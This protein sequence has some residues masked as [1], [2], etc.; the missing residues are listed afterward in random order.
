[1][2]MYRQLLPFGHAFGQRYELPIP[3]LLFVLGGAG[4]VLLSF[5]IVLQR[6]VKAVPTQEYSDT[7][8][9]PQF[10][11]PWAGISLIGLLMLVITGLY[12]SQEVAENIV[13]TLFWLVVWIAVPL[14]C[15]VVG[16]F[17]RQL[18]PFLQTARIFDSPNLRRRLIAKIEPMAWPVWLSWW[19]AVAL[20]FVLAAGELIFNQT[21]TL[22]AVTA[23]GAI[24]YAI[25]SAVMGL[26]YGDQWAMKGEVF[27]VLF[28]TWGRL[29]WFRFGDTGTSGLAGGLAHEPFE[30]AI[31][32]IIFVVLLLVNVGLDGLLSTPFWA[33]FIY[34]L[35]AAISFGTTG[36]R[37]FV[38]A[39][40]GVLAITFVG[41]LYLFARAVAYAGAYR[42]K[43]PRVVL[44]GLL[45]SLLPISF[46]YLLAHNIQYLLVN[47]QLLFPLIGNPVGSKNWPFH[48]AYP[49]NDS[50]DPNLHLLPS[51][52][53][54]YLSVIIIIAVHIMAVVLAHRHLGSKA[55]SKEQAR[56]SEYPWVFA[57][58]TYT[59]LSLWLLAQPLVKEA[60]TATIQK[61]LYSR[62]MAMVVASGKYTL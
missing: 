38:T 54:W 40:F 23:V 26:L 13:P 10:S 59:M 52:F 28:S 30:P 8:H 29:G 3:L 22:P 45:P 9:L 16:D 6:N 17:T 39:V 1:M 48:F 32:R 20:F 58:I 24:I 11:R 44:A 53:Y 33:K 56:R 21:A 47:G 31:S 7:T 57:M 15:A 62:S 25:I 36:Y 60:S 35:P 46:G 14:T 51:S 27:S 43:Q 12:G 55:T 34:G 4:I 37:L 18:N 5:L 19:P 50:F 49:F 41:L 42:S 2:N 61:S